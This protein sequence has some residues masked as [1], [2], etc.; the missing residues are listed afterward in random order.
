MIGIDELLK[1]VDQINC[2]MLSH[3]NCTECDIY[4]SSGGLCTGYSTKPNDSHAPNFKDPEQSNQVLKGDVEASKG[5]PKIRLKLIDVE[6]NTSR[7]C[8]LERGKDVGLG[9]P[10]DNAA[11]WRLAD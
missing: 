6:H 9:Q 4:M 5:T 8:E 3:G 7:I 2:S 10:G 1:E 11:N